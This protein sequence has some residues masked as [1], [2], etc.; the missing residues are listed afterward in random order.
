LQGDGAGWRDAFFYAYYYE[1]GF[2]TPT[3]TAVRTDVAK[4]IRYPGHDDWTELFDLAHDPYETKNLIS[5]PGA[6]TLRRELEAEYDRQKAAIGFRIP[7]YADDP[8][9][10]Q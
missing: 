5:D 7:E 8:S 1:Y 4:L 9:R 10:D 6:A 3:V 2:R